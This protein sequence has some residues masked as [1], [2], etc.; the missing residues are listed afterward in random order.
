MYKYNLLTT[1]TS[2]CLQEQVGLINNSS[3]DRNFSSSPRTWLNFFTKSCA[4]PGSGKFSIKMKENQY[5]KRKTT[6]LNSEQALLKI[7]LDYFLLLGIK[8]SHWVSYLP[9]L[10]FIMLYMEWIS[11]LT[12]YGHQFSK[13]GRTVSLWLKFKTKRSHMNKFL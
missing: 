8:L 13:H 2:A 5:Y 10:M 6:L 7:M 9:V 1:Q 4:F 3:W 12:C 11:K